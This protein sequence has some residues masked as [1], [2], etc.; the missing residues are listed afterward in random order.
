M[1][2]MCGRIYVLRL[3]T[4]ASFLT[5]PSSCYTIFSPALSARD[6]S[7]QP[8]RGKAGISVP[9]V[10]EGTMPLSK[11]CKVCGAP[12][13]VPPSRSNARYCST[14][15]SGQDM[16]GENH[17]HWA[18][19][20]CTCAVCGKGFSLKASAVQSGQGKTCSKTCRVI[21][22]ARCLAGRGRQRVTKHCVVC[23]TAI[24]V[25][26]SHAD[27][28]GRYCSRNC[29]A[30]GYASQL[31]GENNP[32]WK[33][34]EGVSQQPGYGSKY[35]AARRAREVAAVGEFSQD[36]WRALK[37]R[38]HYTCLCCGRREPEIVLTADH[39]VPLSC[40]GANDIMNI[41]PLCKSCNSRK[42]ARTIDY[43]AGSQ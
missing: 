1:L 39:V 10:S 9:T 37:A 40:G 27:T 5:R 24:E 31:A 8:S 41:Q 20:A 23:G 3:I 19:V 15:C 35:S 14:R 29:M 30:R 36:E 4:G 42:G 6:E 7:Q 18:R 26:P 11:T 34:G 21:Y 32:N 17:A 28:E 43:R 38:C 16:S 33:N 2:D 13:T 22:T 12:F 25:K